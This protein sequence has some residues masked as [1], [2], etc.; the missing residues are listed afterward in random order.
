[1]GRDSF[2]WSQSPRNCRSD[3][4]VAMFFAVFA[5]IG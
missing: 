4:W 1:M 3:P 2:G 5:V